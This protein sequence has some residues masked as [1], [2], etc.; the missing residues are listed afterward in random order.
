MKTAERR[1]IAVDRAVG[2]YA[3]KLLRGA[4]SARADENTQAQVANYRWAAERR[5]LRAAQVNQVLSRLGVTP[6]LFVPYR[7]FGLHLDR[8]IRDHDGET[9]RGLAR[10]AF[11]R[12]TGYGLDPSILRAIAEQVFNLGVGPQ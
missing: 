12:W 7:N 2:R 6:I 8:L 10:A 5:E 9:L 1:A 4:A 3:R 11:V